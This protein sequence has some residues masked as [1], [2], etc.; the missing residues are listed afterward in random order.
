VE[1]REVEGI[2]GSAA[3]LAYNKQWSEYF[4]LEQAISLAAG[5]AEASQLVL[6]V[7]MW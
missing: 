4:N 5:S 3:G 1:L 2:R 6:L 7:M